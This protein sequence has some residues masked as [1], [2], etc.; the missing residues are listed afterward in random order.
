MS[1][2]FFAWVASLAFAFQ[3]IYSKVVSKYKIENQFLFNYLWILFEAVI[4][5]ALALYQG[6]YFPT[7]FMLVILGG[8]FLAVGSSCHIYALKKMDIT[9]LMPLYSF[10]SAMAVIMGFIVGEA[11][12]QNQI[13]MI[14]AIIVLSVILTMDEKFSVKSF[15]NKKTF[16]AIFGM[17][18]FTLLSLVV[19]KAS[20]T[21]GY[22]ISTFWIFVFALIFLL[23]SYPKFR[24]EIPILSKNKVLAVAPVA[25]LGVVA[26]LAMN[27]AYTLN[28][29]IT[30]AIVSLPISFVFSLIITFF[31]PNYLE[32]HTIKV[33]IVRFIATAMLFYSAI[34]L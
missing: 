6:I 30:T 23:F 32:K 17:I 7:N 28:I 2:Y 13:W 19:K 12:T 29:P 3:G 11:I 1:F 34:N 15:F 27:K 14:G 21:D 4:I 26:V 18:F 20:V 10:R 8:L 31:A 9:V 24:T 22:L 16:W 5:F 33:Y 25:I